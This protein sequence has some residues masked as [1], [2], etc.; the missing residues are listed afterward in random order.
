MRNGVNNDKFSD[1][2]LK[3]P[4]CFDGRI[5]LYPSFDNMKDYFSWRMVDCHINNLYNTTFWKLVVDGKLTKEQANEILSSLYLNPAMIS[6]EEITYNYDTVK[7]AVCKYFHITEEELTGKSRRKEYVVPRQYCFYLCEKYVKKATSIA[8]GREFEKDHS[9]VIY[10][11]NK[12]K[13]EINNKNQKTLTI[14][15]D[16]KALMHN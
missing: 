6:D 1:K 16:I 14:I 4:P 15:E 11:I 7:N 5:V 9:T 3:Y 8:I 2:T 12:V 13:D 10:G